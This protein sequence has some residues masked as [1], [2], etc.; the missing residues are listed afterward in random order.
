LLAWAE[1][2][3]QH[4]EDFHNTGRIFSVYRLRRFISRP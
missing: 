2:E 4:E 3:L 1:K